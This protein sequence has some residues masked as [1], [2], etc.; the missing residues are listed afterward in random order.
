MIH[1]TNKIYVV[2]ILIWIMIWVLTFLT[3]MVV[4]IKLSTNSMDRK[5]ET[6]SQQIDIQK[7]E[8]NAYMMSL[9]GKQT[10]VSCTN[11]D[12]ETA[13]I[14]THDYIMSATCKNN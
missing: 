6:I 10:A 1:M 12:I 4:Y 5:I 8:I 7:K 13:I 2:S 14:E 9:S 3:F 11:K